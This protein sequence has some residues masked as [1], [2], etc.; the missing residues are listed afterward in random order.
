MALNNKQNKKIY[1]RRDSSDKYY[2][3]DAAQAKISSSYAKADHI[4]DTAALRTLGPI[5]FQMKLIEDDI[6][7]L[8]RTTTSSAETR[9]FTQ[10]TSSIISASSNIIGDNIKGESLNIGSAFSVS[11][12]GSITTLNNLNAGNSSAYDTHIIKGK[13]TLT[14]NLTSS[15]I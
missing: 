10:I 1:E 2:L 11:S 12:G 13:T 15:G 9:A 6:D 5:I 4:E 14:G 8:R 7:E 3:S